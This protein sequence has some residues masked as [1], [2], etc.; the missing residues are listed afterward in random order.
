MR[1]YITDDGQ[2]KRVE[3]EHTNK[4]LEYFNSSESDDSL[5]TVTIAPGIR[6][7]VRDI[8]KL[9]NKVNEESSLVILYLTVAELLPTAIV[10][11]FL[12]CYSDLTGKRRFMMWLPCIGNALYALGLLLPLYI[13]SGDIDCHATKVLFVLACLIS[14]LC[15][16]V[17]GYLSGNASYISDT[18]SP[19]R[20][21]LRLAIVE[22]SIGLTFGISSLMNGYWIAATSHFQQPLWFV[23]ACSLVPFIII[24]FFMR[25]PTGEVASQL[26]LT[27]TSYRSLRGIKHVFGCK[28]LPQK[29][30]WAIFMAFQV[31]VFVQQGQERIFVQFFQS[32]PLSWSPPQIGLFIFV[33]YVVAGFGSWPGV[34]LL[35]KLVSDLSIAAISLLS[36]LLG[37]LIMAFAQESFTVYLGNTSIIII[38]FIRNNQLLIMHAIFESVVIYRVS[39]PSTDIQCQQVLVSVCNYMYIV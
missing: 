11:L 7:H 22:L 3:M 19:R 15:G 26:G 10:V 20:R 39:I 30:L 24:F 36:K 14:G 29:K 18:D 33:L 4:S 25:E 32:H 16:N 28:T 35:Q 5:V 21:T 6:Y 9:S 12:G 2:M 37:S 38:I 31:Y 17:P 23:V 13:C 1:R 27:P 8:I 34:P